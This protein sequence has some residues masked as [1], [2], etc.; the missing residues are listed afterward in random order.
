M[1][2]GKLLA[3]PELLVSPTGSGELMKNT[4]I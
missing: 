1:N 3:I 4:V 2:V